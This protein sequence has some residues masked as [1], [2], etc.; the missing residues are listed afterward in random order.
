[1]GG[2]RPKG[3]TED[4][5]S[6]SITTSSQMQQQLNQQLQQ[7]RSEGAS[8]TNMRASN[9]LLGGRTFV[10]RNSS[11]IFRRSTARIGTATMAMPA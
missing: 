7:Q 8:S 4:K 11:S 10:L 3:T 2:G 6:E 5:R 9:A 1:M